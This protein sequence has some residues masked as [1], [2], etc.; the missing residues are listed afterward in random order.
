[1]VIKSVSFKNMAQIQQLS[2]SIPKQLQYKSRDSYY[3]KIV[4]F[5]PC[6]KK[7]RFN[8]HYTKENQLNLNFFMVEGNFRLRAGRGRVISEGICNLVSPSQKI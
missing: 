2:V 7:N 4:G 5:M 1:M 8:H 3:M 6:F